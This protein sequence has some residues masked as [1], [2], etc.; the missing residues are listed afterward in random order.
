MAP[1]IAAGRLEV[2]RSL[3]DPQFMQN[4]PSPYELVG[5]TW[6]E[7]GFTAGT[8]A[9]GD[10]LGYY[11][12]SFRRSLPCRRCHHLLYY[13]AMTNLSRIAANRAGCEA[14]RSAL[15]SGAAGPGC[16]AADAADGA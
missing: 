11:A 3:L 15:R 10:D 2:Q 8:I 1:A 9:Y 14:R 4:G 5:T 16:C 7:S 12:G 13:S 6:R